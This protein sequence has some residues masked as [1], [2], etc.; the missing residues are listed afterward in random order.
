VRVRVHL[1]ERAFPANLSDSWTD[2]MNRARSGRRAGG[3]LD[4]VIGMALA[5]RTIATCMR[6]VSDPLRAGR[7]AKKGAAKWGSLT[8]RRLSSASTAARTP[9]L[10]AQSAAGV[11]RQAAE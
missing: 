10:A 7:G 3:A 4:S 8:P 9:I 11:R 1:Y 2:V 6:D 5:R